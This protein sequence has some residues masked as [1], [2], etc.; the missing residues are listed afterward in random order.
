MEWKSSDAKGA[1]KVAE[2]PPSEEPSFPSSAAD[3]GVKSSP[4]EDAERHQSQA[5]HCVCGNKYMPD[6]KFCRNCGLRR[7]DLET[8]SF[9]AESHPEQKVKSS[10][11]RWRSLFRDPLFGGSAEFCREISKPYSTDKFK[12][13]GFADPQLSGPWQ[14]APGDNSNSEVPET[15]SIAKTTLC[16]QETRQHVDEP[17]IQEDVWG[18]RSI[19]GITCNSPKGDNDSS[20]IART[21]DN[22]NFIE[23][24]NAVQT[25]DSE[26]QGSDSS[27]LSDVSPNPEPES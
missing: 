26:A 21:G 10:T 14:L 20:T 1:A 13:I 7:L 22:S 17:G 9:S 4:G 3:A 25:F 15:M 6:A 11:G 27:G 5:T 18:S 24:E 12:K 23:D 8:Q 19:S 16:A 2:A